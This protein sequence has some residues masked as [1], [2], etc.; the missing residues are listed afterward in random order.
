MLDRNE[1]DALKKVA[2]E[3]NNPENPWGLA[4]AIEY[5]NKCT[6]SLILFLISHFEQAEKEANW[7]ANQITYCSGYNKVIPC[8]DG[9]PI[10]D[11]Q[12]TAND[13]REDAR[14]YVQKEMDNGSKD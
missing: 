13:W 5:L 9:C 6:P 3:A 7:L 11:K 8:T 14:K 1:I 2:Q 4:F 10:C 12:R